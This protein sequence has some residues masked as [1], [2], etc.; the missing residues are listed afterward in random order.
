MK[1][2][3]ILLIIFVLGC[4]NNKNTHK[5]NVSKTEQKIKKEKP[6]KDE[7]ITVIKNANLT[8]AF[9]NAKLL[10]PKQKTVLLF[11]NNSFYSQEEK[12]ILKKLNVNFY[13]TNNSFLKNY[14]KITFYP[15]IVVL[16]LNK[17]VKYENFTPYE[18]LKAEGF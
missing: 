3:F 2:F 14:F 16:D 9:K 7:N 13:E 17:T 4:N 11:C 8:I 18:I 12:R 5:S 15:T 10:Y 1:Y 6:K